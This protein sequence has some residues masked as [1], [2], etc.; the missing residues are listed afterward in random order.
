[1]KKLIAGILPL[2]FG[3][4][5]LLAGC[6]T[7]GPAE[8]AGESVDNATQGVQDAVTPPGPMEKAGESVDKAA[9]G[10]KDAVTPDGPVEK[11]GE[12]V[13]KAVNP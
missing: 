10:A 13:D 7:Q 3:S 9:E 8:K 5:I 11:A 6:E 12:N 1:M 2:L 4:V